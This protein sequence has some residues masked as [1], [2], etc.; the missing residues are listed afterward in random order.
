MRLND[1]YWTRAASD[2]TP[3][4]VKRTTGIP[5]AGETSSRSPSRNDMMLFLSLDRTEP[6]GQL[7]PVRGTKEGLLELA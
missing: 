6:T 3:R 7:W 1:H 4:N 5:T 2:C